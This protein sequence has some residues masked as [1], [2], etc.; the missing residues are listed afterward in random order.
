MTTLSLRSAFDSFKSDLIE[1]SP[2]VWESLPPHYYVNPA[3]IIIQGQ[4]QE[5]L[6]G[7]SSQLQPASHFAATYDQLIL[8]GVAY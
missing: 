4:L 8:Y 6:D 3:E 5:V 1:C 2:F 7:T